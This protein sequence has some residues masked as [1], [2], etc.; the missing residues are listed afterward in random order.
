MSRAYLAVAILALLAMA[1]RWHVTI[2]GAT[3]PALVF[4]GVIEAAAAL[5]AWLAISR[6]SR[7]WT[8]PHPRH[9]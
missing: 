9:A 8:Y 2:A 3:L 5:T 1:T 4:I 7:V 6:V